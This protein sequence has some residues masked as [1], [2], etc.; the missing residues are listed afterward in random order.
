MEECTRCK[1]HDTFVQEQKTSKNRRIKVVYCRKCK[2]ETR[3]V[4][5]LE[6]DK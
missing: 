6:E 4:L 2:M 3:A 5:I 1:S